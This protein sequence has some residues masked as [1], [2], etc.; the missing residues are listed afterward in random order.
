MKVDV[1]IP[2]LNEER[3]IGKVVA[4]L[5][6]QQVRRILVV[7]NGSH[8]R[9]AEVA[10]YAGARVVREI[11]RGYGAACLRG[12]R[13]LSYDPPDV[14]VFID[15]DYSDHPE[16]LP[17]LLAPIARGEAD[18]VVASRTL[19]ER[20]RGSLTP[21]QRV[22][23]AVACALINQLY[24]TTYTD[25]GPFRAIRWQ[26]LRTLAMRDRNYGWTIE[27]Q[28]RAAQESLRSLEVPTRYRRRIGE[29]KVS[30]TVRG[31][32]GAS[33][34]ILYTIARHSLA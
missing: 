3:A 6:R 33:Y 4:A 25:L 16:D 27:M 14:V 18:L 26:A 12:L 10:E 5:V 19:G 31:T 30:G 15:G 28:I 22:G 13:E 2:A 24:G 9:T 21:Q 8:D 34:K 32:L 23:N 11:E 17:T 20:E 29:S 7:D 1:L